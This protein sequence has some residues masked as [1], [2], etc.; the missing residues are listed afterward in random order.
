MTIAEIVYLLAGVIA[1]VAITLFAG[2]FFVGRRPED[3]EQYPV[4]GTD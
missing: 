1:G 3:D 2:M 4:G